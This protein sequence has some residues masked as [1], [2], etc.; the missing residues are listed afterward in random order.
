MD[1][2]VPVNLPIGRRERHKIAMWNLLYSSSIAL[3]TERGYEDTTVE[4]ITER[5]DVA[6]G[7]FFNYFDRKEDVIAA[8]ANRRRDLLQEELAQVA[9]PGGDFT[10]C[11]K[12]CFAKLG[13]INVA[14]WQTSEVMLTA[15]VRS[16]RPITEAPHTA[17]LFADVLQIGRDQGQLDPAIDI[18]LVGNM[19]RDIYLGALFRHVGA[20]TKPSA[21]KEELLAAVDIMLAGL[22][23]AASSSV[24]KSAAMRRTDS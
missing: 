19:L 2:N 24:S 16:G 21:L 5:A 20:G 12:R 17:R 11:L 13:D 4:D 8:W 9:Q 7:T 10:V 6:R 1:T 3:F 15:W 22:R 23:P 18:D 14:D